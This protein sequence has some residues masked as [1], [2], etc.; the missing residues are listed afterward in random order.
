MPVFYWTNWLWRVSPNSA[1]TEAERAISVDEIER[2]CVNI[3][4]TDFS[5][6]WCQLITESHEVVILTVFSMDFPFT[7]MIRDLF[8][9][10]QKKNEISMVVKQT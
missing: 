2:L 10:S 4:L 6:M 5:S 3:F 8:I 7:N 1:K 9:L